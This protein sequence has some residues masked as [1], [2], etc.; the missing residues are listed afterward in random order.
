MTDEW[1]RPCAIRTHGSVSAAVGVV[2]GAKFHLASGRP[3][4][5]GGRGP[6]PRALSL[7]AN[8]SPPDD[9]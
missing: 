8:S 3:D 5:T 1:L 4:R 2:D 9:E 6:F 7:I